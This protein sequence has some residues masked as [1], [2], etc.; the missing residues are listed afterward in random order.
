MSK[1]TEILKSMAAQIAALER[2]EDYSQLRTQAVSEWAEAGGF[3]GWSANGKR[4]YRML[5][6]KRTTDKDAALRSWIE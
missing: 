3:A 2:R 6:G 5:A 4:T 1:Q